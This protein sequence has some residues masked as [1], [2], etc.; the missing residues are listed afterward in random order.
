VGA[1]AMTRRLGVGYRTVFLML[2][3]LVG[4]FSVASLFDSSVQPVLLRVPFA[5]LCAV[6]S[7]VLLRVGSMRMTATENGVE[8]KNPLRSHRFSW[9][10]V[11]EVVA[12]P[13]GLA[14]R[15]DEGRTVVPGATA[16]SG[17]RGIPVRYDREA[18]AYC[19]AAID[20]DHG[21]S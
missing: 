4:A 7:A 1:G 18:L 15:L 17:I 21:P 3:L 10:K 20:R 14:F 13:N 6:A 8:I 19:Q 5:V 2:A 12:T 16:R 11:E 9:A